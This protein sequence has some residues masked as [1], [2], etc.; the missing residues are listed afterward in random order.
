MSALPPFERPGDWRA[1]VT[2]YRDDVAIAYA[3]TYLT[4]GGMPLDL[5]D[6]AFQIGNV[7][8]GQPTL[9]A[10]GQ[11]EQD[12]AARAR[13]GRGDG[14]MSTEQEITPKEAPDA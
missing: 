1:K 3:D 5:A 12:A 14:P 6:A 7:L 4:S 11:R 2:I 13:R 10:R 8:A 9:T